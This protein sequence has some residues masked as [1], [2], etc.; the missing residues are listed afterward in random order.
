MSRL[1]KKVRRVSTELDQ[2]W[3][4][5]VDRQAQTQNA[6]R[7]QLHVLTQMLGLPICMSTDR[8][9]HTHIRHKHKQNEAV[10]EWSHGKVNLRWLACSIEIFLSVWTGEKKTRE[11]E[12]KQQHKNGWTSCYANERC[13]ITQSRNRRVNNSSSIW[14]QKCKHKR[15]TASKKTYFI[16]KK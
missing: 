4:Q 7:I 1:D 10:K 13:N 11:E 16:S 12:K 8:Q 14:K 3:Q 2:R 6:A 5:S 9:T 15:R